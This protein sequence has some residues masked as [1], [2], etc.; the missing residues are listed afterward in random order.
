MIKI[1]EHERLNAERGREIC[2]ANHY[3]DYTVFPN[4]R[5]ACIS[6]MMFTYALLSDLAEWGYGDRWCYDSLWAAMEG[7]AEWASRGGEGEP[8]G[9]HRHV[10]TGRRRPDGD[11]AKEYVEL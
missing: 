7:M 11:P 3:T 9:W 10:D 5:D 6:R 1:E 4:G 2:E 8:T